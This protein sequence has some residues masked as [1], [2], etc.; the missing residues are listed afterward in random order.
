MLNSGNMYDVVIVG[1]GP[2][3][4]N[5]ALILGRSRRNVL[6]CDSGKPRNVKAKHMHGY[7]TRDGIRPLEFLRLGSEEIKKYGIRKEQMEI[8]SAIKNQDQFELTNAAGEKFYSR[9]ILLATGI[10]DN[11]PEIEG[12]MDLYGTSVFHCPYCDGWEVRDKALAVYARG[13]T[14]FALSLS[15]KTWS[16]DVILCSDGLPRLTPKDYRILEL[17][18]V[19]IFKE[20]ILR[21]EGRNG[22]L[23]KIVFKNGSS[24]ERNALFFSTG[25]KQRSGLAEQLGCEFND[26]GLII[27]NRKQQTNVKG[28][29]VAGDITKD[30]KFVVVAAAEGSRAGVAINIEL[31]EEER[32]GL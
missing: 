20:S 1:G 6:I 9:K 3:G 5:A 28:V 25:Q 22:F 21:L 29:F 31:Q 24:V 32:I 15:L 14:A 19:K 4:L 2:A 12:L 11:I 23:S 16:N 13:K 18:G 17:N 8:V 26:K 30:V 10:T 7:L 27:S